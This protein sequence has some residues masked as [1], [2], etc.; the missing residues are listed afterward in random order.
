MSAT[1]Q[2]VLCNLLEVQ[3][4]FLEKSSTEQAVPFVT[5]WTS[6][7]QSKEDSMESHTNHV[8]QYGV[9]V[10]THLT[11]QYYSEKHVSPVIPLLSFQL[12]VVSGRTHYALCL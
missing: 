11:F 6:V 1:Y 4:V 7:C 12:R 10:P 8:F 3:G 2:A 5:H 9:N